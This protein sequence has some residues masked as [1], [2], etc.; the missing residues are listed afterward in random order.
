M[1]FILN[2]TIPVFLLSQ[3]TKTLLRF[4]FAFIIWLYVALSCVVES[5]PVVM[6]SAVH[7]KLKGATVHF[8]GR[9]GRAVGVYPDSSQLLHYRVHQRVKSVTTYITAVAERHTPLPWWSAIF[10]PCCAK[11]NSGGCVLRFEKRLNGLCALS[12]EC[13]RVCVYVKCLLVQ[14][15]SG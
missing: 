2:H 3:Q 6:A 13:F 7:I 12:S 5:E 8:R 4:H 10:P 11:P 15:Y 14:A 9:I 1:W